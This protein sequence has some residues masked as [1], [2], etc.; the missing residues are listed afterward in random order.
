V[1]DLRA[2]ARPTETDPRQ[3]TLDGGTAVTRRTTA[4]AWLARRQRLRVELALVVALYVVYDTSRGVVATGKSV[5]VAHAHVI[6]GL[7]RSL[8]LDPEHAVQHLAG[9]V[10]ALLVVFGVTYSTLHLLG[11]GAVLLWLYR[12]HPGGY[13]RLRLAVLATSAVALVGFVVWPTAPPRLA[14]VGIADTISRAGLDLDSR[15]L[16]LL[17]NPYAAFPS[18]HVAYAA[19]AGFAVW[20]WARSRPVRAAGAAYPV[21]V[22]LEVLATGNHFLLDVVAGVAVAGA[23]LV[24]ARMVVA[25]SLVPA[26]GPVGLWCL[27]GGVGE[28]PEGCGER[29]PSGGRHLREDPLDVG[30]AAVGHVGHDTAAAVGQGDA[31]GSPVGACPGPL[32]EAFADQALDHAAGG[33]GVDSQ[34]GGKV[35]DALWPPGPHDDEGPELGQGD[36]LADVGEAA[37][38]DGDEGAAGGDEGVDEGPVLLAPPAGADPT[39]AVGCHCACGVARRCGQ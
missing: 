29:F 8:H 21:W 11:T 32:D 2:L 20:R 1:T 9:Q 38:G 24:A 34:G 30:A 35:G 33:G 31:H 23:G 19:L 18:L 14:G 6:Y 16:T 13:V 27:P 36:V 4:A 25:A 22:A 3:L 17:Y 15:P 5:A 39:T 28:G 12:A 26:V 10:P 37:G 7:E